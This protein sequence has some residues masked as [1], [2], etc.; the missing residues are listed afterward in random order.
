MNEDHDDDEDDPEYPEGRLEHLC[1]PSTAVS[2]ID[3]R[4]YI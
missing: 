1:L 2:Q 4:L 3:K